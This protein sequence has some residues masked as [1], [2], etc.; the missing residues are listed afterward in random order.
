MLLFTIRFFLPL[1]NSR[2]ILFLLC[3][4]FGGLLSIA[5]QQDANW[6][7]RNY[8]FYNPYAFFNDRLSF[9]YAP[10]MIQTFNNPTIDF[11]NYWMILH[12]KPIVVGFVL[13][14]I[15][16]INI[17]LFYL[18][19]EEVV[20]HLTIPFKK[21]VLLFACI[22]GFYGVVNIAEIGTTFGDN[23]VSIFILAGLY[24]LINH[25]YEKEHRNGFKWSSKVMVLA[26]LIMGFAVGLKLTIAIYPI[27]LCISFLWVVK[28]FKEYIRVSVIQNASATYLLKHALKSE[29][30]QVIEE[31]L[32]LKVGTLSCTF[33]QTRIDKNLCL[34]PLVKN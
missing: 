16:G 34:C 4:L 3:S 23:I 13:G 26:G 20:S 33:F 15:Q 11:L 18:I 19:T 8:H 28:N 21:W 9:D 22:M 1:L 24:L 14:C 27:A 30:I 29:D 10:A 17:F 5:F 6:D 32:G 2:T 12:F 31:T 7:L 25:L